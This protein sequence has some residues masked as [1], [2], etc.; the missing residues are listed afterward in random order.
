VKIVITGAAGFVGRA[1]TASLGSA[2]SVI[3]VDQHLNGMPGIA[4]DLADPAVLQA[5]FAHGCDAVVHLATVPG[6][7]A[8]L[9]PAQ[10]KR[11]NVDGTMA[12]ID[13]AAAAGHTPRFIFASSI[14]VFGDPM[15]ASIDDTTPLAPRMLY[16]GHK[17]IMEEWIATQTRRGAISGL[18]L[19][20]PGIVAR[21]KTPSGMKSA[22][23]SNVFHALKSGEQIELPVSPDATLWLMSLMCLVSNI[24]HALGITATGSVTLP[25]ARMTLAALV[26]QIAVEA[27]ADPTLA[28]YAPDLA[29]EAAFGRQPPLTTARADALGFRHDGDLTVLVASALNTL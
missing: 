4:G 1:L 23:M 10:A 14:A 5:A 24:E 28:T 26:A 2:H 20:F 17:A 29:L 8:E 22:F 11:V 19:R 27:G 6:G 12:L 16:G 9:D 25:A 18:S 7:A 13:A 15:P 21:P 3:A